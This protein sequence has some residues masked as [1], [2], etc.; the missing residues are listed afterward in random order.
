M[1]KFL[2][3][4]WAAVVSRPV[5]ALV[6]VMGAT[7]G[8][9]FLW[10]AFSI[11]GSAHGCIDQ[12]AGRYQANEIASYREKASAVRSRSLE[13]YYRDEAK[14][15]E[16]RNADA[17]HRCGQV[18]IP[19]ELAMRHVETDQGFLSVL[20]SVIFGFCTLASV[21]ITI[22]L[23][24]EDLDREAGVLH[25]GEHHAGTGKRP[26]TGETMHGTSCGFAKPADRNDHDDVLELDAIRHEDDG[27]S[28][29]HDYGAVGP[30]KRV[31][32]VGGLAIGLSVAMIV[33]V[34]K[35]AAARASS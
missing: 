25:D 13:R 3:G 9:A 5:V 24:D 30:M 17:E 27:P 22:T 14:R 21:L 23:R 15:Q 10:L 32:I 1:K 6:T 18:G 11:Y 35:A 2:R 29:E 7:L 31:T 12:Q 4:L 28:D 26:Q 8:M 19:F 16:K 20:A 34:I 33:G